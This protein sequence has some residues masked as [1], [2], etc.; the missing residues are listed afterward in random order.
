MEPSLLLLLLASKKHGQI[1]PR[2]WVLGIEL[3]CLSVGGLSLPYLARLPHEQIPEAVPRPS[4]HWVDLD[5]LAVGVLR[6]FGL[7]RNARE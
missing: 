1:V 6:L 5:G 4:I 3:D 7:A 2:Q